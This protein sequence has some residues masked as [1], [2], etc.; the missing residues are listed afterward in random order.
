MKKAI[1]VRHAKSDW[2]QP[3]LPDIKRPLGPRGLRDAPV[4]AKKLRAL[5]QNIDSIIS[6]PAVRA[7]ETSKYFA[8]EFHLKES[9]II[10]EGDLYEAF[11]DTILNV[12]RSIDNSNESVIVFGH[13][14]GFTMFA[15]LFASNPIDNIPTCGIFRLISSVNN[16]REIDPS[17][18][19]L[20]LFIKP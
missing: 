1:F 20:D 10:K 16:W 7:Y 6:S 15:N 18:T 17:N 11:A 14:P 8:H 2:D 3:G 12:L 4:M 13:N 19:E 9:E 5:E